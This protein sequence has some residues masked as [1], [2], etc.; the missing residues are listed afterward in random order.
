MRFIWKKSENSENSYLRLG[1][2]LPLWVLLFACS[3]S[4]M[5]P[6]LHVLL[7]EYSKRKALAR[8]GQV[9]LW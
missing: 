7:S 6:I 2:G 5:N 8:E 1:P 9:I 3:I 4:K